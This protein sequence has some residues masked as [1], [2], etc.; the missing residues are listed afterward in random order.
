MSKVTIVMYHYVR[1]MTNS[2]YPQIKG[3]DIR[4]F[5]K[6]L[7]YLDQNYTFVRMEDCI[8]AVYRNGAGFPGNAVLLTFD[9]GYLEHYTEVFPMLDDRGI[10]GSFFPPV[11]STMKEKVLD[12]NKIHFILASTNKPR[13][14]LQVLTQKIRYYR[15]AFHL[16]EPEKYYEKIGSSEHPYDPIEVIIFK[17]ILQRELPEKARQQIL[18]DLFEVYVGVSESVFS[19]ELY[20]NED[21]LKL[22]LRK[23]MFVGGHGYSHKWLNALGVGEQIREIK[24]TSEF[25]L[26]IGVN[27]KHLVM[28]YPYGAFDKKTIEILE[29]SNYQLGLTTVPELAKLTLKN[30][31]TLPRMD[32]NEFR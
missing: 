32:T 9:D 25:L 2:R 8:E 23:G 13:E 15:E 22:M 12:V 16:S 4:A 29:N 31:F 26:S 19:N 14:L 27:E 17:R 24:L 3:L 20:M 21:Q 5:K 6:Q 18:A 11:Q 10:Q 1:D 28:C 30:R 7:D